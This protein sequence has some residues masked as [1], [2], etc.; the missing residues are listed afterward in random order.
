MNDDCFVCGE[1]H[2][3][4][5]HGDADTVL[6]PSLHSIEEWAELLLD[7][8]ESYG[9][10]LTK[11]RKMLEDSDDEER[12]DWACDEAYSALSDIPGIFVVNEDD[13]FLIW[14]ERKKR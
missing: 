4:E 7:E 12:F 3:P 6:Q 13:S 10:D 5:T 1:S 2:D 14:D 9:A 8:A 11:T